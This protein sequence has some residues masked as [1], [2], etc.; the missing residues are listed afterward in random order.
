MVKEPWLI[1]QGDV[2]EIALGKRFPL[3]V[4]VFRSQLSTAR[5]GPNTC[6]PVLTY[7]SFSP[8][9]R[10]EPQRPEL[11]V[12]SVTRAYR[13]TD[14][15]GLNAFGQSLGLKARNALNF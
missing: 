10:V 12:S 5:S 11:D 1:V 9:Y 2:T 14:C 6:A 15:E 7:T 4:D 13:L 3:I 8:A